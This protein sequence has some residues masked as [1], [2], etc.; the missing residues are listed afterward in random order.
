MTL[1]AKTEEWVQR[2]VEQAPPLSQKQQDLI[3]AC[4]QGAVSGKWLPRVRP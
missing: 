4:F 1:D 3:A 2:L